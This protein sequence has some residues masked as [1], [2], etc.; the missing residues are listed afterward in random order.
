MEMYA[1]KLPSNQPKK[2]RQ[3]DDESMVSAM[4][5]VANGELGVNQAAL[6]FGVPKTSLKDRLL[7]RVMHGTNIGPK[8]YLNHEEEQELV[9]FL[10]KCS[11]IAME[12]Q[13]TKC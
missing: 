7:G 4:D 8:P 5:T 13:E 3:W 2:L 10:V 12:R 1:H 9:D 6:E 11:K